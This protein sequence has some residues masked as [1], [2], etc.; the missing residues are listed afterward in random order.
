[1]EWGNGKA[2]KKDPSTRYE[3]EHVLEWQLVT[4]FFDWMN[5]IYHDK[6]QKFGKPNGS[7]G[8]LVDFCGL[9]NGILAKSFPMP[10]KATPQSPLEHIRQEYPSKTNDYKNE[11]VWLEKEINSPAKAQVRVQIPVIFLK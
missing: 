7:A 6:Q 3:V 4:G 11:F 10:G 1:M 5:I 8:Q 9:W 2:F